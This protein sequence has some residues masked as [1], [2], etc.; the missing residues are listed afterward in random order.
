M[1]TNLSISR[2]NFVSSALTGAAGITIVPRHVLGSPGHPAASDR[3][4]VG[5]IGAGNRANLLMD[6][7]PAPG[8]IAALA[9]CYL[10]RAEESAAKR[11]KTWDVYGDYR[12]I[13]DRKDIDAVIIATTD[14][15][16]VL[17]AIHACQA[18]KDIYAEKPLTV[19]IAEGRALVNAARKYKRV[20]QVGTQ[21]RS[22]EM[23]QI[24][25]R[26][27]REGG[28]G[29]STGTDRQLPVVGADTRPRG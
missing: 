27:V 3:I 14:H 29:K 22:M 19:Y 26:L 11:K 4:T 5:F 25:C 21:Q 1:K 10:T 17:P 12:R 16:R 2:R 9:D 15:G 8:Q 23:D 6:Q 24:A 20:V 18:G 7:L 13:L 28:L